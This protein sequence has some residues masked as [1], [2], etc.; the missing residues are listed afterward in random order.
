MRNRSYSLNSISSLNSTLGSILG[1]DFQL[2]ITLA[3]DESEDDGGVFL[4][5][6]GGGGTGST[7]DDSQQLPSNITESIL[8]AIAATL[9]AMQEVR[10]EAVNSVSCRLPPF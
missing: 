5:L 8:G 2:E 3:S 9:D 1:G 10:S 6:R 7:G 4:D